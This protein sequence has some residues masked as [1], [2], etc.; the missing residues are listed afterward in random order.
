MYYVATVTIYRRSGTE[1]AGVTTVEVTTEVEAS[2][3]GE[4]ANKATENV[5]D[6]HIHGG[7]VGSR[8]FSVELR[9]V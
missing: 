1:P 3:W 6:D 4:A 2:N 5:L 8:I 9:A 7:L